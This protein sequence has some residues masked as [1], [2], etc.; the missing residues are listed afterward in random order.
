MH[1]GCFCAQRATSLRAVTP[2]EVA[3]ACERLAV[4]YGLPKDGHLVHSSLQ[5]QAIYHFMG[6]DG[7]LKVFAMQGAESKWN[8]AGSKLPLIV[9]V[10]AM[11]L[12]RNIK[13][14]LQRL[15]K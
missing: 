1:C 3:L 6:A 8:Q 7:G 13:P 9:L 4:G 14:W 11:A 5:G 2:T 10:Q 15:F 12:C